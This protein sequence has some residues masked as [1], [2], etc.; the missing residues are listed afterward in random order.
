MGNVTVPLCVAFGVQQQW[1][2]AGN[3]AKKILASEDIFEFAKQPV[4]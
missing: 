3:F 2:V 1:G 4:I